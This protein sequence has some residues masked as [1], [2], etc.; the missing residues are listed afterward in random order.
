MGS[1]TGSTSHQSPQGN[2]ALLESNTFQE[3]VQVDTLNSHAGRASE[4]LL[5]HSDIVAKTPEFI[6]LQVVETPQVKNLKAIAY[7][8]KYFSALITGLPKNKA[9]LVKQ[10][11]RSASEQVRTGFPDKRLEAQSKLFVQFCELLSNEDI[12][13]DVKQ[14]ALKQFVFF[15]EPGEFEQDGSQYTSLPLPVMLL[16]AEAAGKRWVYEDALKVAVDEITEDLKSEIKDGCKEKVTA[17]ASELGLSANRMK[18]FLPKTSVE[19]VSK[20]EHSKIVGRIKLRI[21]PQQVFET[22]CQSDDPK[23]MIK[24]SPFS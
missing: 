23:S 16:Q 9:D 6:H 5:L 4:S 11:Y 14:D 7:S 21:S 1:I 20:D 10:S 13:E 24:L 3:S 17:V 19:G 8:E 15:I 22:L 18:S 2:T 12:R